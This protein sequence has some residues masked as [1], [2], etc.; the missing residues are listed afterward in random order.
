ML[1]VS[2]V[3]DAGGVRLLDWR[4]I[5]GNQVCL[6]DGR[7]IHHIHVG[8]AVGIAAHGLIGKVSLI[9][10]LVRPALITAGQD[11]VASL[12]RQLE[13]CVELR[14]GIQFVAPDNQMAERWNHGRDV[15]A[16][17]ADLPFLRLVHVVAQVHPFHVNIRVGGVVELNPVVP[18]PVFVHIDAVRRTHLV[19]ANWVDMACFL[20]FL[21]EGSEASHERQAAVG[22][23]FN[24]GIGGVIA[25]AVRAFEHLK[26]GVPVEVG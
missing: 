20:F 2:H 8:I 18:F 25:V 9:M 24:H 17:L 15:F 16:V 12:C 26:T 19:D 4:H 21:G 23:H 14:L 3:A 7:H 13:W 10:Q 22:R 1:L 11:H 6:G 5:A